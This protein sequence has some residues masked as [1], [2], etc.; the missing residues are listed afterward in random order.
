MKNI[1][2][3]MLSVQY[4]IQIIIW[5]MLKYVSLR[6]KSLMPLPLSRSLLFFVSSVESFFLSR[7]KCV[8]SVFCL[9]ICIKL[10]LLLVLLYIDT[11]LPLLYTYTNGG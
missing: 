10:L 6:E 2:L 1:L 7:L 4:Y 11:T 5:Y 9:L 8:S 3:L